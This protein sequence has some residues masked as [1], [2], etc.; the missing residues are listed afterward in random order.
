LNEA[1]KSGSGQSRRFYRPLLTSD[2]PPET[3]IVR[4]GRHLKGAISGCE[5][6]QQGSPLFDH[7]V[8]AQ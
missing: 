1:G 7:L 2:L 6:S 4:V 8:D 3:D 5:Q